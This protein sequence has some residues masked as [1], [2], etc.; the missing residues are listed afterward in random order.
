[1]ASDNVTVQLDG[2]G[3]VEI[4]VLDTAPGNPQLSA[5][6]FQA[7]GGKD[8]YYFSMVD[9]NLEECAYKRDGRPPFEVVEAM[10]RAGHHVK[11]QYEPEPNEYLI[12]YVK[13][14]VEETEQLHEEY[15]GNPL[16]S[17]LTEYVTESGNHLTTLLSLNAKLSTEQY[18]DCMWAVFEGLADGDAQRQEINA[19]PEKLTLLITA[20]AQDRG[21]ISG[22]LPEETVA[23]LLEV[24]KE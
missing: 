21:H 20:V 16:V 22:V 1:M 18:R 14:I 10:E 11:G 5:T 9:T 13:A 15:Y 12:E 3:E 6:F 8:V 7:N 23:S 4:T 17:A 2:R 19:T 24:I